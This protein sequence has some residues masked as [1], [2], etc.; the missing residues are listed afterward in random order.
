MRLS[1]TQIYQQGVSAILDQQARLSQAQQQV[2]TGKRINTPSD[3]PVGSAR[4]INIKEQIAIAEQY[5]R[6]AGLAV[7]Q[8]G[9]EENALIGIEN[10]LQRVRELTVQ[11][12]TDTLSPENR[13]SIAIEIRT[14]LTE[15]VAL[16]NSKDAN[17]DYLFAGFQNAS[18]PFILS[19]GVVSYTGDQGQSF[20]QIG[21]R[22][23]V[24]INDSGAQV[25]QLIDTGNGAY[26]VTD[27][28]GNIGT[29]VVGATTV[30][31][32]FIEDTYTLSFTQLLPDDPITYQVTGVVS[33]AVAS[34]TFNS[35]D[36][37]SFNGAVLAVDGQPGDGDSFVIAPASR[38]D[39]FTTEPSSAARVVAGVKGPRGDRKSVV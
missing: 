24:P 39:M 12:N 31:G 13:H 27:D 9:L 34:G 21:P 11:A 29:G 18:Q 7:N 25:F 10:I 2:S 26:T 8:L 33:G 17:G 35:G 23:Q 36:E 20:M 3:D 19:N 22:V 4:V 5:E 14:R 15:I 6:N 1:T 28:P 16:A 37:I 32:V 30:D 38:Q